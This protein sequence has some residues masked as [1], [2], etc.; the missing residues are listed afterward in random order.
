MY[1]R[2][3]RIFEKTQELPEYYQQVEKTFALTSLR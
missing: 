3:K 1:P 2:Y